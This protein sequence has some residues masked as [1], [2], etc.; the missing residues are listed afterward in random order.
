M[1]GNEG[2]G[3]NQNQID[4]CDHFVYIPQYTDKTA[5]LNV[6]IA[7]SIIFHHFALWAGYTE[8]GREGYKYEVSNY[9]TEEEKSIVQY[10][11]FDE[12]DQLT[13]SSNNDNEQLR[14]ERALKN[15]AK[16]EL[17]VDCGAG[18]LLG[19]GEDKKGGEDD[20][21]WGEVGQGFLF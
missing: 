5:S 14:K 3:L 11:K 13:I 4:I 8:H 2:S 18:A 9:K 17:E 10:I 12:N 7:G 16:E 19:D 1:L 21:Y 15:K 6:A 20:E